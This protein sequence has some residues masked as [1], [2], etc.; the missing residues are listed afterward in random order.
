MSSVS[1]QAVLLAMLG[2]RW[3]CGSGVALGYLVWVLGSHFGLVLV[4]EILVCWDCVA[5]RVGSCHPA[6]EGLAHAVATEIFSISK[7]PIWWVNAPLPLPLPPTPASPSPLP[8]S[9]PSLSLAPSAAKPVQSIADS[10]SSC[11]NFPSSSLPGDI[12]TLLT[13]LPLISPSGLLSGPGDDVG[14]GVAV[15]WDC[16]EVLDTTLCWVGR[17]RVV[18]GA[19]GAVVGAKEEGGG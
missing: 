5:E 2:L 14:G 18:G 17:R 15:C 19:G 1:G 4:S 3:C 8:S 13:L 10:S 12:L 9:S 7:G 16:R 11:S 6:A